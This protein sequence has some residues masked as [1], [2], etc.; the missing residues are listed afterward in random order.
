MK[1]RYVILAALLVTAMA[2]AGCGKKKTDETTQDA[3]VTVA[4][5]EN[6]DTAQADDGTLVDMQKSDDADIKNVIGDETATASK[7][8]IV[9]GTGS[10]IQGSL[11]TSDQQ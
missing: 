11:C 10:A 5:A 1:K 8:I 2:A 7:V 9:N 3:Q 4:P 6:T